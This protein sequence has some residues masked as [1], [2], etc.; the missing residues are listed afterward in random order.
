[1]SNAQPE[2]MGSNKGVGTIAPSGQE[3]IN[4][5]QLFGKELRWD[6][7]TQKCQFEDRMSEMEIFTSVS[8]KWPTGGREK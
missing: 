5:V 7:S 3:I 1:M 8:Y 4:Q 6:F 2:L